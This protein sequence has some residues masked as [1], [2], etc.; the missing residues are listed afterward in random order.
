MQANNIRPGMA[1]LHQNQIYMVIDFSHRT[2]GNKRAFM[3]I[4]LKNV[5]TGQVIQQ[6]FSA[7]EDIEIAHL[8]PKKSQYLYKDHEGYHFMDLEDYHSYALGDEVVGDTKFYLKENLELELLF[9]EGKLIE[10]N[11]PKQVV[12]KVVDSP[13]GVKGDSVSNNTKSAVLETGLKVNIPIFISEGS[14][15]KVDT[16]TGEYL[17]KE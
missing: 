8:D 12:L 4:T 6:R 13:P 1:V 11:L 17:G 10:I 2:P 16:R 3:Q 9:H 15:I 7:T 14:M 5:K